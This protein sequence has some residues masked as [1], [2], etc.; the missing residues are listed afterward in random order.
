MPLWAKT[1]L[2][3]SDSISETLGCEVYLKLETLQPSHS[4][5][6]RGLSL[7]VQNAKRDKGDAAH[8]VIASGGNA[9]IAAA[10]AARAV[11]VRCSTFMPAGT[12]ASV[13][14]Y[15]ERQGADVHLSGEDYVEALKRA[16]EFLDDDPD[17][18]KVS[19]PAYD[20]EWLWE[21]HASLVSEI[22]EQLPQGEAP[23]AILCAVG[24]GGLLGGI[25]T[26]C[27]NVGWSHVPVV[28][29]ETHGAACFYHSFL[30]NTAP[31]YKLPEGAT[32]SH[33]EA[34][35]PQLA[36]LDA[37]TSRASSL[38]ARSPSLGVLKLALAHTGGV[39]PVSVEDEHA[40][41]AAIEFADEHKILVEL[42]CST[43]L[44]PAF[45]PVLASKLFSGGD[46][47]K[48][49]VFIVCGGYK[50]T[51]DDLEGYR[52]HLSGPIEGASLRIGVAGV[53]LTTA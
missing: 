23:D 7:F 26:G 52:E 44:V 25:L 29:L 34:D 36:T 15:V 18:V 10:C 17:Q 39:T 11:G 14:A 47:R 8:L 49:V 27:K 48:A 28:A 33:P 38:G 4:F 43:A 41:R 37:I 51:L 35:D 19:V 30:L 12:P 9:A 5:K 16:Q 22:A 20:H 42:A 6:Y 21:G 1:P 40:M 31:D 50:I 45:E 2:V 24:G 46:R 3:R 13:I 53:D 32:A